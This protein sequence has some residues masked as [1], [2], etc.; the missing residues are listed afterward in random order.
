MAGHSKWANIQYRKGTQDARKAR[1]FTRVMREVQSAARH[2]GA[3]PSRNSRLRLAIERA[4][5]A[6]VPKD[7]IERALKRIQGGEA[8]DSLEEV[9]YEGYGA[10]GV[11][12]LVECLTDNRN[13]TVSEIRHAFVKAGGNLGADGAVAYLF[14]R[15][16]LLQYPVGPERAEPLFDEALDAGAE[17]VEDGGGGTVT[18]TVD[19]EFFE[20]V[21]SRLEVAG[22][23]P[24]S[25][26]IT[27]QA[28][29][30]VAVS[31][32]EAASVLKLMASLEELDDVQNL[33]SNA[34]FSEEAIRQ[35]QDAS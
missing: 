8:A 32:D 10:G 13:R 6:N 11:A 27:L 19:P 1:L 3:D 9:R 25:G 2:G 26:E 30:Q 7:R 28:S 17:D 15:V 29:T 34:D 16:G 33:Y 4:N 24:A 31:G 22:F 14:R 18:V 35:F 20:Q 5:T 23:T 21:R 12:I